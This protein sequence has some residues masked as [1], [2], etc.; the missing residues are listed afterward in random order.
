[1]LCVCD[2]TGSGYMLDVTTIDVTVD[3]TVDVTSTRVY[4]ST[5]R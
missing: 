4:V 5:C 2:V 3:V 1:M